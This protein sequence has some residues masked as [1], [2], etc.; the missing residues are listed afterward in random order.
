MEML[1]YVLLMLKAGEPTGFLIYFQ[2]LTSCSEHRLAIL[3]QSA[4]KYAFVLPRTNRFDMICEPRLI[5][6]A[7]AGSKI[8][9]HDLEMTKDDSNRE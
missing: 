8:I 6:K 9:F 3:H 7:D 1:V 5:D 2:T 4:A